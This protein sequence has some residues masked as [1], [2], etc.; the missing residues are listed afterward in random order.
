MTVLVVL[1]ALIAV[2]MIVLAT[3]MMELK[4]KVA[5]YKP[6]DEPESKLR[7]RTEDDGELGR[8]VDA[9]GLKTPEVVTKLD[10]KPLKR[11]PWTAIQH[12]IEAE[13]AEG[14]N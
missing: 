12:R 4:R 2:A 8:L 7:P 3:A 9:A 11:E 6:L 10:R 1:M 13:A 14:A 5:N